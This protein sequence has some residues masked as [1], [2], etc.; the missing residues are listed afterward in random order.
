MPPFGLR[1]SGE[2]GEARTVCASGNVS[3][4]PRFEMRDLCC[5]SF[6]LAVSRVASGALN[7]LACRLRANSGQ[8]PHYPFFLLMSQ[9]RSLITE[10]Y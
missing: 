3:L 2:P 7:L 9:L 8:N 4:L 5:F 6:C 1:V 10:A